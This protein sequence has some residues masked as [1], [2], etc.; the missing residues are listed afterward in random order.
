MIYLITKTFPPQN[1]GGGALIKYKQ[2]K[3][4]K[5]SGLPVK[6]ICLGYP[7]F[8]NSK[9][10]DPD[11]F[12]HSSPSSIKLN[13]LK[14]RLGLCEDYLDDWVGDILKGNKYNFNSNDLLVPLSGGD[15]GTIKLG[16]LAKKIF[17]SRYIIHFHDPVDHSII[18]GERMDWK[19][20]PN[21]EKLIKNCIE[22][23]D[24][25]IT[26][27]ENLF[28]HI[29]NHFKCKVINIK[30]GVREDLLSIDNSGIDLRKKINLIYAGTNGY[31]QQAEQIIPLLEDSDFNCLNLKL[32]GSIASF[33]KFRGLKNVQ[34]I[35]PV[36]QNILNDSYNCPNRIGF[37]SLKPKFFRNCFPSKIYDYIGSLTPIFSILPVGEAY[38][39]INDHKIGVAVKVGESPKHKKGLLT[40]LR[41]DRYLTAVQVMRN[42]RIS[43]GF[44]KFETQFVNH[45]RNA[46]YESSS[47]T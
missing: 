43:L 22:E 7:E 37:A 24:G 33:K 35:G 30:F 4:L 16:L 18:N 12:F 9:Y 29:I 23:S 32:Y 31:A 38:N 40:I 10:F 46:Y 15:L 41:E 11:I 45:I 5:N 47:K 21:R 27:C 13:L 2:Y 28:Q 6:V 14:Q 34:L 20:H 19:F 25:A 8:I 44:E 39:F 1:E 36:S 3:A 26:S 42:L 17:G